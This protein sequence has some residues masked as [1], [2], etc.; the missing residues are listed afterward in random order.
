MVHK[1][2]YVC[3]VYGWYFLTHSG[4]KKEKYAHTHTV[5]W[6]SACYKHFASFIWTMFPLT[7]S[8]CCYLWL[9][10][11][12]PQLSSM[13]GEKKIKKCPLRAESWPDGWPSCSSLVSPYWLQAAPETKRIWVFCHLLSCFRRP[14]FFLGNWYDWYTQRN[15]WALGTD[16]PIQK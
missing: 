15:F 8:F 13:Q 9:A 10:L 11:P 2:V 5:K 7:E 3:V 16:F 4:V 6:C 12:V 1:Y 14:L